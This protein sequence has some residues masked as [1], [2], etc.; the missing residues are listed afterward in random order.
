[1]DGACLETARTV[2]TSPLAHGVVEERTLIR[3]A[4]RGD[5]AAF[6]ELVRLHDRDVLRLALQIV[7]SEDE[8]RDLYQEAFLKIYRS[9]GRFRFQSRFSTWVYRIVI[10]VCLDHLRRRRANPEVQAPE[11]RETETQF[12]DTVAEARATLDPDQFARSQQI[13]QRIEQALATLNPRERVVFELKHYQGLKLRAIGE[14]FGT[15]E[16]TVKNCLF[17][18]TQKL[19]AQLTGLI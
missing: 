9:L 2:A 13:G 5:T 10:N 15:S 6:E 7:G 12:F 8:A 3:R 14:M 18:A 19:R 4:Q 16:E 17:R 11:R 1:M